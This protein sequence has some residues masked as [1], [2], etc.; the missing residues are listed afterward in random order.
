MAAKKKTKKT[1]S[2][3]TAPSAPKAK[4]KAKPSKAKAKPTTAK[5]KPSKAKPRPSAAKAK[6]AKA[7]PKSTAEAKPAKAAPKS[8]AKAK[9]AP[10]AKAPTAKPNAKTNG[11]GKAARAPVSRRDATGHLN[12]AYAADL[13]QKS[14]ESRDDGG[15]DT[16]AFLTRSRSR[17]G[18][19]EELGE[20]AVSAMTSGA[21]QSDRLLDLEVDEERGGPFV[22]TTGREEFALGTDKSNPRK[23]TREPFPRT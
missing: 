2:T 18:L 20:E 1:S 19:A 23:A 12:P 13:R 8:P 11:N 21:D 7:K 17:D 5:P 4:A 16:Q 6:P 9:A 3:K 15:A 14:R 10:N 22:R